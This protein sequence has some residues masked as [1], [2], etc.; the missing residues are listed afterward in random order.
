VLPQFV[1]FSQWGNTIFGIMSRLSKDS[2]DPEVRASFTKTMSGD[3]DHATGSPYTPLELFV[4]ELFRT[5]SPNSGSISA[6]EDARRSAYGESPFAALGSRFE[7]HTYI[8]TPHTSTSFDPRHW[9]NPQQFDP[10][11]YNIYRRAPRSTKPNA[12]R[13]VLPVPLRHYHIQCRRRAK[14]GLT[15]SG[16]GTVFGVADG[17]PLPVCDYAGLRRS[18]SAIGAAREAAYDPSVRGLFAQGV[19]RKDRVR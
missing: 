10:D 17:K 1:A 13:S 19:E 9:T 12:N 7:R 15:N 5:I 2:G 4:M 16:F 6:V 18:A 8:A 11:R 14:A 3:Y